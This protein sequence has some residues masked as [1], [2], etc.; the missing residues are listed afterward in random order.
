[1]NKTVNMCLFLI[2]MVI[3]VTGMIFF[4]NFIAD[5]GI[6]HGRD[7]LSMLLAGLGIYIVGSLAILAA[8]SFDY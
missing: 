6:Q 3:W 7:G 1:M 5:Q 2:G 4:S 8:V